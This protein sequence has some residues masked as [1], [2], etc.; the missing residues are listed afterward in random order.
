MFAE[1]GGDLW[2]LL[3]V[4]GVVVLG[5]ALFYATMQNRKK[6]AAEDQTTQRATAELYAEEEAEAKAG[7][8]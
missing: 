6:T 5:L 3:T 1:G 8:N 7:K 4:G 2:M